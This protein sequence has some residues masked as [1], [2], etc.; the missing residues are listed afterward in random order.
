[1]KLKE[2]AQG[3]LFALSR[4]KLARGKTKFTLY[5]NPTTL[6]PAQLKAY[7][8]VAIEDPVVGVK[9]LIY[10]KPNPQNGGWLLHV[11]VEEIAPFNPVISGVEGL[12]KK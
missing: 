1:M 2:I 12:I 8:E 5:L 9:Y 6:P 4:R 7:K 11:K 3:E 10:T